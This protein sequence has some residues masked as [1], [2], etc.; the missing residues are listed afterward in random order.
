MS[1]KSLFTPIKIGKHELEHRVVLAPLTR[2]R[3]N[4]DGVPN[5]LL[6]EYYTQRASKGGLL[7]TEATFIDPLAGGYKKAPGIYSKEQIE[8]WK[9][10][11]D[12]VHAKG[13]IIFLQLWHI[14]RAGSS[15]L[16]P[17][18]EP[19]VSASDIAIQGQNMFAGVDHEKPHALTIP[20]IKEW[21]QKYRQAALNAIEAG[22]DGVEIHSANGYL[23][24]QFINS[25]SNK[26]TDEYGGSIE[27]RARFSLEIV[28]AITEAIGAD[29]TAIRFSPGGNFQDMADE[30]VV[31]TWSYLTSQLQNNHPD[32]AYVHFIE[33]RSDIFAD[34]FAN[35]DSLA[36]YRQ[37]WKGPFIASSG[38]S[39]AVEKAFEYSEKNNSLIA[40]GRS[41]IANP[42][43]PERLR[44]GWPLNAYDRP[45]FYTSDPKGYTDYPFY[46]A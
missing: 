31:D 30:T 3:A 39:T 43:L 35:S 10:V 22:F 9:K 1:S 42:D 24:D 40:F 7:I 13:A 17:N 19:I 34:K 6:V 45:T 16:N 11:T 21:V 5:D 32:L 18:G 33:T 4:L 28:D 8:G 44:N 37:I 27:N 25:S 20:E 14:G 2:L 41:F 36:P 38:Y 26:R 29:R 12:S 23:P 46:K 15:V